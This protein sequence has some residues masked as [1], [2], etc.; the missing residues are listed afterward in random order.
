M[1]TIGE[2]G[3]A[4]IAA[5]QIA[6]DQQHLEVAA[7]TGEPGLT[8][9]ALGPEGSRDAHRPRARD[10]RCRAAPGNVRKGS[11]TSPS[12]NAA[13]RTSPSPTRAST[14]SAADSASCSSPTSRKRSHEFA[15]VL[16]P[17]GR[18]AASRVGRSRA[19]TSGRRSPRRGD[20]GRGADASARPRRARHVPMRA[21]ACDQRPLRGG[22]PARRH[23]V[24]RPHSAGRR[25]HPSSTGRW[26]RSSL[27]RS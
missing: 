23:G 27:L 19:S 17:G 8:I 22:R 21:A 9:A 2:V 7:G 1:S 6:D 18:V 5:L 14:A 25:T 3:E 12:R 24:G 10:A 4:M 16:K 15:R 13:R 26:C 20:R 11:P